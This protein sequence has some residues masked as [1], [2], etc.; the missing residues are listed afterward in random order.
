MKNKKWYKNFVIIMIGVM[1]FITMVMIGLVVFTDIN[2]TIIAITDMVVV[3]G[4]VIGMG[5]YGFK[6]RRLTWR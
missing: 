2:H 4:I 1:L 3:T 5:I 6:K